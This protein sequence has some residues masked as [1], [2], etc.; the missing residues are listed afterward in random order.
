MLQRAGC[1]QELGQRAL[2]NARGM[3]NLD[4]IDEELYQDFE[5]PTA[6][7]A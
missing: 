3:E 2:N 1:S 4:R 7:K 5:T 6:K